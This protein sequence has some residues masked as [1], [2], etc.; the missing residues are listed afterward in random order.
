MVPEE[1]R[2]VEI[3]VRAGYRDRVEDDETEAGL[4]SERVVALTGLEVRLGEAV[5]GRRATGCEV[6]A[7]HF[8]FAK[9]EGP[10][11][12]ATD[13]LPEAPMPL[14]ARG[15]GEDVAVN[16]LDDLRALGFG[17]AVL[18]ER[19]DLVPRAAREVG[20]LQ[21]PRRDLRE[22]RDA[23]DVPLDERVVVP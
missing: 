20:H 1:L 10:A 15:R 18:G 2:V 23:R 11:G 12:V 9:E 21:A 14:G 16:G 3:A 5:A 19:L 13:A 22:E 7:D 4:R 6:L 17:D 8:G